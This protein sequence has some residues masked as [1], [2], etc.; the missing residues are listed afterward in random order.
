[1]YDLFVGDVGEYLAHKALQHD[2]SARLLTTETPSTG[3]YYTS[4]ADV[5]G[6]EQFLSVCK[7]ASRIYYCPPDVWSGADNKKWT[8]EL[9][10]YVKQ[11]VIVHGKFDLPKQYLEEELLHDTRRINGPQMWAVGCSITVG[12]GVNVDQ[13]WKH[14]VQR[15]L[16]MAMSELNA[17]GSSIIWQSD[18]IVRSDIR[19]GDVVFWGLTSHHRMPIIVDKQLIHFNTKSF[20]QAPELIKLVTPDM[21]DNDTLL[22][23]NVMAVR[24]ARNFCNKAGAELITLGLMHDFETV[25]A[26]YCIQDF[27]QVITWPE[28][29]IDLGTDNHH[30]GPR[31]HQLFA[32]KFIQRYENNRIS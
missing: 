16:N 11:H 3:T 28:Q 21:L 25:Y 24:R 27:E 20:E 8:E 30:P 10:T 18:Q 32:E 5:G 31:Q 13:T 9:L 15:H 14:H 1:M 2:P 17:S 7:T 6:L 22:Y 26:Q 4:I 19:P 12:V 23:H 29:Y